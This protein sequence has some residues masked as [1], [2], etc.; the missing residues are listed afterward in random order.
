MFMAAANLPCMLTCINW[1]GCAIKVLSWLDAK[2]LENGGSQVSVR[3]DTRRDPSLWNSGTTDHKRDIYVFLI[4]ALLARWQTVLSNVE[5]VV[6]TVYQVRIVQDVMLV[7]YLDN[8]LHEL[9]DR[10][11]SPKSQAIKLIVVLD[12]GLVLSS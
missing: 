8:S 11:K 4:A 12:M 3:R 5:A 7:E 10:L 9:V 6:A 2:D 1:N